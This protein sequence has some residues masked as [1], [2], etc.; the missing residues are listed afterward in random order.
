MCDFQLEDRFCLFEITCSDKL[1]EHMDHSKEIQR[2]S[3][4]EHLAPCSP[5]RTEL[6]LERILPGNHT[7]QGADRSY[8]LP[9]SFF[10]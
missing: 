5:L 6:E 4:Q 3:K 10:N 2:Y 1:N 8:L 9:V 7:F